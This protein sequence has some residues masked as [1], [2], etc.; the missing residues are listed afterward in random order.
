VSGRDM[1]RGTGMPDMNEDIRLMNNESGLVLMLVLIVILVALFIGVM[2]MKSTTV[3]TRIAGSDLVYQQEFYQCESAGDLTLAQFDG[4]VS[5]QIMDEKTNTTLDVTSSVSS[6]IKARDTKVTISYVRSSNPPVNS[7][8]SPATTITR[9]YVVRAVVNGKV[10]EKGVW[11]SFPK[12]EG[13]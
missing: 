13:D 10:I 11:K 1:H 3:E 6:R 5:T 7:G 9:Y 4:L 8:M 2:L 12:V